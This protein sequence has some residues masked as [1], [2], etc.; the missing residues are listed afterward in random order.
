MLLTVFM[1]DEPQSYYLTDES[2]W[3]ADSMPQ[4]DAHLRNCIF[5]SDWLEGEPSAFDTGH[6]ETARLLE[7]N[8]G[9]SPTIL[10]EFD[11]KQP[12]KSIP[13]D[14]TVLTLFEKRAIVADGKLVRIWP[15]RHEPRPKRGSAGF[16]AITEGTIFRHLRVQLYDEI[17]HAVAQAKVLSARM[18]GSPVIVVRF[19]SQTDWY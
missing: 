14:R 6:R 10:G 9:V 17:N 3:H 19:L 5:D 15:H 1:T 18:N 2:E 7:T 12:G 11:P 4:I 16:F 8:V 13:P